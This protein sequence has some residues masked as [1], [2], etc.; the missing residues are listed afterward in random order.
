ML[1]HETVRREHDTVYLHR[2]VELSA[3]RN[4]SGER[5]LRVDRYGRLFSFDHHGVEYAC[6]LLDRGNGTLLVTFGSEERE[7]R[8][9]E[10]AWF[11]VDAF[12]DGSYS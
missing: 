5:E 9:A 7:A 8:F 2:F 4:A 1:V 3:R 6:G 10:L 12:L 11:E